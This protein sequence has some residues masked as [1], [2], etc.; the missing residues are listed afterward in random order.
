MNYHTAKSCFSAVSCSQ[1][2]ELTNPYSQPHFAQHWVNVS[3]YLWF[4]VAV[5]SP[6]ELSRLR[7]G[8]AV[9]SISKLLQSGLQPLEVALGKSAVSCLRE[10]T[11]PLR[12]SR[13]S[14]VPP[15]A[16][17]GCECWVGWRAH[18]GICV[19]LLLSFFSAG[20]MRGFTK[21]NPKAR[22]KVGSP[23]FVAA[24]SQL[25]FSL[26]SSASRTSSSSHSLV[27]DFSTSMNWTPEI[28]AM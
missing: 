8:A 11:T 9:L 10:A 28:A 24:V 17:S 7:W 22:H 2:T 14:R 5:I 27:S 20:L 15:R 16:W 13:R 3:H 4:A 26:C 18:C 23:Q 12:A 25:L 6:A 19:A 21:V 1:S